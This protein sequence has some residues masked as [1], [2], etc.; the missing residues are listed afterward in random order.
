MST[1][2]REQRRTLSRTLRIEIAFASGIS[3]LA[4]AVALAL[5]NGA[6]ASVATD[7]AIGIDGAGEG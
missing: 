2:G 4:I 7:S 5:A 6:P 1:I 3:I